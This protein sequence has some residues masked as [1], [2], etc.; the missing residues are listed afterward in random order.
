M[1]TNIGAAGCTCYRVDLPS[2]N[3]PYAPKTFI[4]YQ[5]DCPITGHGLFKRAGST[6]KQKLPTTFLAKGVP[7]IDLG[8]DFILEG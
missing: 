8:I 7:T 1:K 6:R 4:A 2:K 5:P 3:Y